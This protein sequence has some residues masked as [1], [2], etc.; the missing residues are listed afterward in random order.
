VSTVSRTD[1]SGNRGGA[2][3]RVVGDD[4]FGAKNNNASKENE[5]ENEKEGSAAATGKG[6]KPAG[7][8]RKTLAESN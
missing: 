4:S 7:K 8:R 5:N 6:G 1:N 2:G 3:G